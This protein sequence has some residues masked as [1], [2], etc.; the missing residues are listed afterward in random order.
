[1]RELVTAQLFY[2]VSL[3]S[4]LSLSTV[5]ISY[6]FHSPQA[7]T[8]LPPQSVLVILPPTLLRK[9]TPAAECSLTFC[10]NRVRFSHE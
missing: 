2:C 9:Q 10:I 8:S 3:I 7:S 4:S 6:L 5:I 1:M